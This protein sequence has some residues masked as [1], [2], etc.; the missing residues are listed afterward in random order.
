MSSI[1]DAKPPTCPL[2]KGLRSI[3]CQGSR[4]MPYRQIHL[5][6]Q[7]REEKSCSGLLELGEATQA[8]RAR[9]RPEPVVGCPR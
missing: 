7:R 3:S 8:D 6:Q 4:E 9:T 2:P 5:H 1:G